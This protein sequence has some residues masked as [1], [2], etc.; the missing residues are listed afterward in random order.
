VLEA[1]IKIVVEG[2][3]PPVEI[4]QIIT[5]NAHFTKSLSPETKSV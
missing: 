2:D 3:T 1:V 5:F 4:G